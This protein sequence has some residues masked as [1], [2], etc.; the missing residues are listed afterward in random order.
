MLI[1]THIGLQLPDYLN[2]FLT[3]VRKFN[4]NYD[5]IFLVNQVNC[6]NEIFKIHNIKTYPIEEL[7]TDRVN[8]FINN[9]GYGNINTVHQ[10]IHYGAPDYWCVT[11]ARLFFIYEYCSRNN[12]SKFFHFENDIMLYENLNTIENLII[13]NN[14]YHNQI[15]ITRGT[16]NKIM[17]GFMYVDTLESFNHLL[18]E[19][20]HYLES[21]LDL[22]S[23]GIDHLNEM[24]LL[25]VYQV[26]N[27]DKLINLPIAPNNNLT[28][29]FEFYQSVFDP[30]T[31]GQFLD[32][33]PGS[34]GVSLIPDS[35][36]GT[37]FSYS[38]IPITFEVIDNLRIPF[39]SYNN[40]RYKINSLHIHSKRLNLFLS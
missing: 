30:A 18:T 2:T 10:N 23:F 28:T 31:Y 13:T 38:N 7:I 35:I 19:I 20:N 9:F 24:G 22:F 4:N 21:K 1:L 26:N 40:N 27:P 14:L 12:V 11:A 32:G 25:H 37:E 39:V 36:I 3:Q 17:T 15:S 6:D 29:D 16:N 34:P 5:I 33:T 8:N